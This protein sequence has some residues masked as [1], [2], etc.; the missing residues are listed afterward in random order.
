MIFKLPVC[1]LARKWQHCHCSFCS[2]H[3][4]KLAVYTFLPDSCLPAEGSWAANE[5]QRRDWRGKAGGSRRFADSAHSCGRGKLGW[6]RRDPSW[7]CGEWGAH[8][9]GS[10]VTKQAVGNGQPSSALEGRNRTIVAWLFLIYSVASLLD[11]IIEGG[12]LSYSP[13]V[14]SDLE[15]H[16]GPAPAVVIP[17]S[18]GCPGPI[19]A[20]GTS[21]DATSIALGSSTSASPPSE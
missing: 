14:R 12:I 3:P 10:C 21:R 13:L 20:L 7:S 16:Q 2:K 9:G 8:L 6:A 18:S 17:S 19:L 11:V 4:I 15:D 1:K 5:A